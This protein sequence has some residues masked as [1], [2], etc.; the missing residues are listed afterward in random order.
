MHGMRLV[1]LSLVLAVA[2]LSASS[3]IADKPA[4]VPQNSVWHRLDNGRLNPAPQHARLSCSR[5][6]TWTCHYDNVPEPGL[7]FFWD[8][9]TGDFVGTDV[10]RSWECPAWFPASICDNVTRVAAGTMS[11]TNADGTTFSS[12]FDII[13]ARAGGPDAQVLNVYWPEFGF[14][15]PWFRTFDLALDA[16]PMPLPFNGIDWPPPDCAVAPA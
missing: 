5:G 14:T 3:A 1:T 13:L 6:Q 2:A 15:C 4:D 8:S 16:N 7:N 12:P 11:I 10:T 9:A